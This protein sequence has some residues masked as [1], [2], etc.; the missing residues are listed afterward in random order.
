[1]HAV[2]SFHASHADAGEINA[3]VADYLALEEARTYRRLLTTRCG[4]LALVLATL[5]LGLRWLSPFASW[6]AV[7]LCAAAPAWAWV[8]ELRCDRRLARRLEGLPEAEA[9]GGVPGEESRKKVIR[10]S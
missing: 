2:S 8:A 9:S 3:I 5:G 7:G 1:M 10:N 4:A 6:F